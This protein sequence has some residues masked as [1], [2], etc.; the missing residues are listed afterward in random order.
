MPS[1]AGGKAFMPPKP[2][3]ESAAAASAAPARATVD[4]TPKVM[5]AIEDA[6]AELLAVH[7]RAGITQGMAGLA[8]RGAQSALADLF[9]RAEGP[10]SDVLTWAE[11]ENK[12]MK[13]ENSVLALREGRRMIEHGKTVAAKANTPVMYVPKKKPGQAAQE[14]QAAPKTPPRRRDAA[15]SPSSGSSSSRQSGSRASGSGK[16]QQRADAAP[17]EAEGEGAGSPDEDQ[18]LTDEEPPEQA[19][20]GKGKG[21]A[22]RS[23]KAPD[24][25]ADLRSRSERVQ[26]ERARQGARP[27]GSRREPPNRRAGSRKRGS[28]RPE[29]GRQRERAS[30]S[31]RSKGAGRTRAGQG[32]GGAGVQAVPAASREPETRIGERVSGAGAGPNDPHW[33]DV[34]EPHQQPGFKLFIGDLMP[35]T[36]AIEALDVESQS[37]TSFRHLLGAGESGNPGKRQR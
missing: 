6:V 1:G 20:A 18:P 36:T 8:V 30:G 5:T 11:Q 19:D 2:K 22:G 15:R 25:R 29:G 27:A 31:Q 24:S 26:R 12:R 14:Q 34:K 28:S 37:V 9:K 21:K 16:E 4:E 32:K 35:G 13:T 23:S 33:V 10:L 17:Q 7:T 3:A